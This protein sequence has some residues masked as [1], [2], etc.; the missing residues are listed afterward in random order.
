MSCV[1]VPYHV[2]GTIALQ[3]GD[4]QTS[5]CRPGMLVIDEIMFKNYY[6]AS[7][8]VCQHTSAHTSAK[9]EGAQEYVSLFKYQILCDMARVSELR[10]ILQ[11][12]SPLWLSFTVEE[13]QI[14]QQGPKSPSMISPKWLSPPV[15]WEQP[16]LLYEGLPDP[17]RLSSKVQQ[18]W[19]LT[20][21]IRASHT[22]ARIGHFDVDGFY[23]LNL[24]SYT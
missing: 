14:Y 5:Q 10:L 2:K 9:W 3:V 23:D 4:V 24:L 22:S 7:I 16:A 21:M 15:P 13:L 8:R 11:Q 18:M 6:T 12:P 1:L 17:S 19:A 20:E